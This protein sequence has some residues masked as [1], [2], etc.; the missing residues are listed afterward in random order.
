MLE[1]I[2]HVKLDVIR[3]KYIPLDTINTFDGVLISPGPGIPE[4]AGLL[5]EFL[6]RYSEKTSIL[7][8]CLGHQAIGQHFGGSLTNTSKVYHGISSEVNSIKQVG[9][10]E[11]IGDK[12]DAAR[13]HSWIVTKDNLPTCLEVTAETEDGT[14]MAMRHKEL[15]IES[16]QFHP[17]SILTPKGKTII[18][19]WIKS[20]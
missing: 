12:F 16:V 10:L 20:L 1:E 6:K 19:N 17:E 9:I 14:I 4:E 11:N 5:M 2:P 7:G 13:Y 3:N 8:V 15:R 18:E